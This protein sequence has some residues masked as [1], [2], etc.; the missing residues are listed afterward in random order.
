LEG[1]RVAEKVSMGIDISDCTN[2]YLDDSGNTH[3]QKIQQIESL[4][5]PTE[6][7]KHFMGVFQP[8]QLH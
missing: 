5:T 3:Y 6:L 8:R 1:Y 2:T 4:K 7:I